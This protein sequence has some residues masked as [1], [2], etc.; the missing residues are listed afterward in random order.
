MYTGLVQ[1][2]SEVKEAECGEGHSLTRP[3]G[4]GHQHVDQADLELMEAHLL[5][6]LQHWS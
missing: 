4:R 5:L 3:L 6:P 2:I 1:N